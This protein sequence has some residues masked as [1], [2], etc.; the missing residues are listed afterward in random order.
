MEFSEIDRLS[1]EDVKSYLEFLLWHYRVIDGFW[2]LF[3]AEVFGQPAA[4]KINE[5][6][7]NRAAELAAK[8][9]LKRFK[10]E[11]KGLR[12]F[13]RAQKLFPWYIIV[14]YEIEEKDDEVIL[15][16]PRCPTQLARLQRGL[17]EY[18]CKDMHRREIEGFAKVVDER[19]RVECLFA[20]PDPHPAELFCQ[21][22]FTV[23]AD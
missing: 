12:G 5:R 9:L 11:E 13:V 10:I 16:V 20:P 4:D 8:D 3:V 19:I 1:P 21:W 23:K 17:P 18:S 22:R 2:Y 14:G 15:S 7:W 6:V